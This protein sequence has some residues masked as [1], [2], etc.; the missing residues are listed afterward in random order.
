V[1][2]LFRGVENEGE[3]AMKKFV[4]LVIGAYALGAAA[5]AAPDASAQSWS[6]PPIGPN[7]YK[8][9]VN[10]QVTAALSTISNSSLYGTFPQNGANAHTGGFY[11][12]CTNEEF[13]PWPIGSQNWSN[14]AWRWESFCSWANTLTRSYGWVYDY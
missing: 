1:L 12:E 4:H 5:L 8:I 11:T 14:S 7:S 13:I 10:G 2:R 6:D 9:W 3:I